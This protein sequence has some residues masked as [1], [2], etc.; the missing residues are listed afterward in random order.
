MTHECISRKKINRKTFSALLHPLR[1]GLSD[2]ECRTG[3]V[4]AFCTTT[5]IR[6]DD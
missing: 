2:C 4:A 3:I 1:S 6:L 5:H